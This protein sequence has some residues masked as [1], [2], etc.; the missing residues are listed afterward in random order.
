MPLLTCCSEMWTP[1]PSCPS[2]SPSNKMIG[3]LV[4]S[5][6]TLVSTGP[7]NILSSL[8]SSLPLPIYYYYF[9]LMG[10]EVFWEVVGGIQ[11]VWQSKHWTPLPL[12]PRSL[13]HHFRL[14]QPPNRWWRMSSLFLSILSFSFFLSL[15]LFLFF[16]FLPL[17]PFFLCKIRFYFVK[18]LLFYSHF[19]SLVSSFV[20]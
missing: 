17:F 2:H 12:R 7:C 6:N 13:L 18:F 11:V 4:M 16:L 14:L 8:S 1:Q 3:S 15:S 20:R 10:L 5:T 19:R 9:F